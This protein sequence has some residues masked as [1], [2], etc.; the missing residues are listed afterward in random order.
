MY[1]SKRVGTCVCVCVLLVAMRGAEVS[2]W[3]NSGYNCIL[4]NSWDDLNTFH[5]ESFGV[6]Q[7]CGAKRLKKTGT[8]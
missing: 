6:A 3:M 5:R 8:V 4:S 1:V 2:V 7:R